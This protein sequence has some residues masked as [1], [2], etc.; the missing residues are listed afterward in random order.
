MGEPKIKDY[1]NI[2]TVDQELLELSKHNLTS[3]AIK[4]IQFWDYKAVLFRVLEI[5]HWVDFKKSRANLMLLNSFEKIKNNLLLRNN[6]L[7][8]KAWFVKEII[9]VFL[10]D[11]NTIYKNS[12]TKNQT[13][14]ALE[15][16]TFNKDASLNI[17]L[18][19]VVEYFF[20]VNYE[21]EYHL[22]DIS[23]FI[24][25]LIKNFDIIVET[26]STTPS[27]IIS[28]IKDKTGKVIDLSEA[29]KPKIIELYSETE[30]KDKIDDDIQLSFDKKDSILWPKENKDKE[31]NY[32]HNDLLA[33]VFNESVELI[34]KI[35]LE[36]D[37]SL[38]KK[39]LKLKESWV[40]IT[41]D[42]LTS[43]IE[44]FTWEYT[45]LNLLYIYNDVKK[46]AW[47]N[48]T[49]F[50]ENEE[51]AE[52]VFLIE[53]LD[54][55]IKNMNLNSQWLLGLATE[56]FKNLYLLIPCLKYEYQS[57]IFKSILMYLKK[58]EKN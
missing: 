57:Y 26:L 32:F 22:K 21:K 40:E 50:L 17:D 53:E 31:I 12:I 29:E 25:E 18:N 20:E 51:Y 7:I 14:W 23:Y 47:S 45:T 33:G 30:E 58:E 39:A 2:P 52:P 24:P 34:N 10:A 16:K 42:I 54:I 27:Y 19:R 56:I 38:L 8:S 28:E 4:T 35:L 36:S 46:N 11:Y 1:T 49:F 15:K 5:S 13:V 43:I 9:K 44:N 3:N 6:L 41:E 48:K 37:T 55:F